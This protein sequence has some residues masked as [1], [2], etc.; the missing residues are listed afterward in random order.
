MLSWEVRHKV[1]VGIAKALDYLHKGCARPAVHR[2]VKTSN[3]LLTANFESQVPLHS[4]LLFMISDDKLQVYCGH[5]EA[6]PTYC[7]AKIVDI[8]CLINQ[9]YDNTSK[10]SG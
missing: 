5:S 4:I 3:I 2:D 7:V 8:N 1:A 9:A 10:L 6:C